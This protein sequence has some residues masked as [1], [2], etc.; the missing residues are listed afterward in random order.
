[1]R[2]VP[3][4]V[5]GIIVGALTFA[6]IADAAARKTVAQRVSA[7]EARI[8]RLEKRVATP[9]TTDDVLIQ[10]WH[11]P[12]E[13]AHFIPPERTTFGEFIGGTDSALNAEMNTLQVAFEYDL[14][15]NDATFHITHETIDGKRW[16][17]GPNND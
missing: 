11:L 15:V 2:R 8:A 14:S 7:L 13:T 4:I 3:Y 17:G 12:G 1:M 5:I 16:P 10:H 9:H 6:P